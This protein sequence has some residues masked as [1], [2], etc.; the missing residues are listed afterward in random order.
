MKDLK[1]TLELYRE[2]PYDKF[3]NED[4]QDQNFITGLVITAEI[5]EDDYDKIQA[6]RNSL[7]PTLSG[8]V[9]YAPRTFSVKTNLKEALKYELIEM[10]GYPDDVVESVIPK[11]LDSEALK[12]PVYL[13]IEKEA[14]DLPTRVVLGVGDLGDYI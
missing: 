4:F 14:E 9:Y 10:S 6:I 2:K 13:R 5:P 7:E 3:P 12:S 1:L 8:V 11:I